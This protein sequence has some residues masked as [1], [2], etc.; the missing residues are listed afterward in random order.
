MKLRLKQVHFFLRAHAVRPEAE[1]GN[2]VRPE[3]ERGKPPHFPR[4]ASGRTRRES[5]CRQFPE[6]L[7]ELPNLRRGADAESAQVSVR[8][9][10]L[11]NSLHTV[12]FNGECATTAGITFSD[13]SF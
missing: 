10:D 8:S 6:S 9:H 4:S 5:P 2:A 7:K 3:A 13:K 12:G 1:R 11:F